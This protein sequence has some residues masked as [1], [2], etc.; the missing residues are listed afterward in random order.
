MESAKRRTEEIEA[1]E[2]PGH[3]I[4]GKEL[5]PRAEGEEGYGD[6]DEEQRL[7]AEQID[8]LH[9]P[10]GGPTMVPIATVLPRKP[11]ARPLSPEER[12]SR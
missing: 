8:H 7:P 12:W 2:R 11:R 6:V 3:I 10:R 5:Q 4:P 1:F 9:P